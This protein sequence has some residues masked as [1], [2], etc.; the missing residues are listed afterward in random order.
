MLNPE[1]QAAITDVRT[2]GLNIMM[3][4]KEEGKPVSFVEDC[5]VPLEHLAD[6]TSRL[7]A[8]FEK[9]GTRGTWYAHAG[10]RLSACASGPQSAAG[11]GCACDARNRRGGVRDGA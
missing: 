2:S 9:H 1:L 4:M 6:Y 3:S 5:A 10:F 7:T 8:I 11:K